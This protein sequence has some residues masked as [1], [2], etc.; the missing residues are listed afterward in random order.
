MPPSVHIYK[1]YIPQA[2]SPHLP[3]ILPSTLHTAIPAPHVPAPSEISNPPIITPIS[4]RPRTPPPKGFIL[5]PTHLAR[6]GI[7][8]ALK[9][10]RRPSPHIRMKLLSPLNRLTIFKSNLRAL[11][12]RRVGRLVNLGSGWRGGGGGRGGGVR[13]LIDA[14][15]DVWLGCRRFDVLFGRAE[16]ACA[17]ALELFEEFLLGFGEARGCWAGAKGCLCVSG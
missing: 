17:L 7:N 8:I 4:R 10:W 11:G 5:R 12:R 9:L 15:T 3:S 14:H 1:T 16:G 6:L 13:G 2:K